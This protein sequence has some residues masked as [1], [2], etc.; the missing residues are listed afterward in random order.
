VRSA[1]DAQGRPADG[2]FVLKLTGAGNFASAAA[3]AVQTNAD[4]GDGTAGLSLDAAGNI[5]VTGL[6]AGTVDVDPGP[7]VST[8]TA[9][10]GPGGSPSADAFVCKLTQSSSTASTSV[11]AVTGLQSP[12]TAGA[13]GTFTVTAQHASGNTLTG[14][15]GTIHFRTS[16]AQAVLPADYTFTAADP[17]VHTF[18]GLKLKT[19]GKQ[20]ITFGDPQLGSLRAS[21]TIDVR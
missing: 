14:Y 3:V 16:D 1:R 5:Y 11:L 13:T 19:K 20:V 17:G 10:P 6:F 12:I 9:A 8:L 21:L 15:V 4:L 2:G 7:R 18:T